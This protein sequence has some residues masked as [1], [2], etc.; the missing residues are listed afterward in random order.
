VAMATCA[1]ACDSYGVR[2]LTEPLL[3]YDGAGRD[4]GGWHEM[5][6]SLGLAQLWRGDSGV[7]VRGRG[8]GLTVR[9]RGSG[10][11]DAARRVDRRVCAAGSERGF[12]T[13]QDCLNCHGVR[14]AEIIH[15]G[16][17]PGLAASVGSDAT[18]IKLPTLVL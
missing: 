6:H 15:R 8:S 12:C 10:R 9:G 14:R 16:Q 11:T 5:R 17:Q 1:L 7:T 4:H 3:N 2:R 13:L 18:A